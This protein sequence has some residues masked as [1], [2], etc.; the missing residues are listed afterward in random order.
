MDEDTIVAEE[1]LELLETERETVHAPAGSFYSRTGTDGTYGDGN[2][3][4][5]SSTS[6]SSQ[7]QQQQQQQT[8][9]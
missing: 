2:L 9:R 6:S 8:N 7:Q 3:Q 4:S 5:I 1:E